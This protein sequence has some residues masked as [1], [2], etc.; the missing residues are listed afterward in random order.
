MKISASLYS[1][2]D[3]RLRDMVQELDAAHIDY[4]HIDCRDQPHVFD[5]IAAIR[6]YSDT[7]VDVHI[8]SKQPERYFDALIEQDVEL[9]CFQQE[10]LQSTLVLP[11]ELKSTVG[12]AITTNTPIEVFDDYADQCS[13]I[14]L[15]ATTPGVS[16]G[17]FDPRNYERIKAFQKRY[18]SKRIHVDGGVNNDIS[19][20]LR[21]LGVYC[22]V[23][24][25]YLMRS[26]IGDS[27]LQLR[28]NT[29]LHELP[30][31]DFMLRPSELPVIKQ[32]ELTLE[33][34][35]KTISKGKMG[36]CFIID[37]AYKLKGLISN[38]DIRKA[39]I[40][41]IDNL[42]QLNVDQMIN[43]KP[44]TIQDDLTLRQAYDVIQK[45]TFP[46][47]F[48]PIVATDNTFVGCITVNQLL[49]GHNAL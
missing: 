22:S 40:Q 46:I 27:L 2:P 7:P 12:L 41:K 28:S 17:Q 10:Q 49:R 16:G 29:A 38:A 24:G 8:I 19:T 4:F 11:S 43:P 33:S 32:E 47:L 18:P 30:V 35:L 31:S 9:V 5:D 20:E 25:S 42:S 13:F 44:I 3:R 48:L 14:L 36:A 39:M 21:Q 37:Q 6:T 26:A 23:S 15:M 1:N 45:N 34:A